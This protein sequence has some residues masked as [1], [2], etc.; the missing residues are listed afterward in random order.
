MEFIDRV[1]NCTDCGKPLVSMEDYLAEIAAKENAAKKVQDEQATYTAAEDTA[2]NTAYAATTDLAVTPTEAISE[3]QAESEYAA[4]AELETP[5]ESNREAQPTA[6][7]VYI[8]RADRYEDLRSSASAFLIVGAVMTLLALLSFGNV[9]H[10]PFSIPANPILKLMF[11]ILALGSFVIFFRTSSEARLIQGQISEEQEATEQLTH[12]FLESYTARDI[13]EA[14]IRENG[15]LRPEILA[16][17]RMN[18]IQDCFITQYDLADQSYV[19]AL[20]EDIYAT[21]YDDAE[22][23]QTE[24]TEPDHFD[25]RNTAAAE[26]TDTSGAGM[27]PADAAAIAGTDTASAENALINDARVK[28]EAPTVAADVAAELRT[29]D[30]ECVKEFL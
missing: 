13:D 4:T 16:L 23:Q 3:K 2:A 22:F 6:P 5:D 24:A 14:V 15:A 10:L 9:F 26:N 12:W 30:S 19:D 18:Y 1:E 27:P 7:R 11:V 25:S 17:K 28:K 21:L 8:K 29:E 20:S